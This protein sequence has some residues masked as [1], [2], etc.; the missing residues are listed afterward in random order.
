MTDYIVLGFGVPPALTDGSN[1]SSLSF[2]KH[3]LKLIIQCIEM[4][5]Q[6]CALHII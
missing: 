5:T 3:N 1:V 2:I 4:F 6:K